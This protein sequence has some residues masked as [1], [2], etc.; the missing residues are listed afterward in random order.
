[1]NTSPWLSCT[2]ND[3]K[4]TLTV[5]CKR[6]FYFIGKWKHCS[7]PWNPKRNM[8]FFLQLL[9]KIS[10]V[11]QKLVGFHMRTANRAEKIIQQMQY[12]TAIYWQKDKLD[13]RISI[14]TKKLLFSNCY[15]S[16]HN[17]QTIWILWALN[18]LAFIYKYLSSNKL[19]YYT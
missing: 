10:R 4:T 1:M 8:W 16:I 18:R 5:I 3:F 19:L 11:W 17:W 14:E 13:F 2:E 6:C 7:I 15:I 9:M 12:D